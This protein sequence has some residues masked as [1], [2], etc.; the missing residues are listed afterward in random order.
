MGWADKRIREYRNGQPSTF[1]ESMMLGVAHPVALLLAII[2]IVILFYGLWVH[3]WLWIGAGII[4]YVAG[5][6]YGQIRRWPARRI[7]MYRQ[8]QEATWMEL[9]VLEHAHPVHFILALIGAVMIIY[10]LSM[11]SWLWVSAGII[12]NIFGHAYTWLRE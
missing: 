6:V 5:V 10:G 4:I 1:L 11:Q 9:R 2:G 3:A 7:E 8:G 12:L